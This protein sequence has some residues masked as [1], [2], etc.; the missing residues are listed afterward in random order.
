MAPNVNLQ[1]RTR[2]Q[3]L[4]KFRKELLKQGS[5]N[6]NTRKRNKRNS[7]GGNERNSK[8]RNVW[9]YLQRRDENDI[10][11]IRNKRKMASEAAALNL[12]LHRGASTSRGSFTMS[13]GLGLPLPI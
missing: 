12:Q 9:P 10:K 8:I 13:A 1:R 3:A 7:R 5:N 2:C 4:E 11:K 6:T